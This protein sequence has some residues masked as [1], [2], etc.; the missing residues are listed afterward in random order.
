[1]PISN[2]LNIF[3]LRDVIL[4]DSFFSVLGL[5]SSSKEPYLNTTD[6]IWQVENRNHISDE[7]I[8]FL[9]LIVSGYTF[10]GYI[11]Y[12]KVA[13]KIPQFMRK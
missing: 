10:H 6:I 8:Q 1:M 7:C 2:S 3:I 12:Y 4:S 13:K 11:A 5:N 9:E